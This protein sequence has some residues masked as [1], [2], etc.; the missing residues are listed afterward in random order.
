MHTRTHTDSLQVKVRH[1]K[2]SGKLLVSTE[3]VAISNNYEVSS[4]PLLTP[5]HTSPLPPPLDP[6]HNLTF[7][8]T[9]SERE[10]E[11]RGKV[12]L[13]YHHSLGK[14]TAMMQV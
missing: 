3:L 6:T 12:V 13:P 14:K 11:E 9:L 10:R 7:D 2:T 4:S 1:R 8:L 5:S